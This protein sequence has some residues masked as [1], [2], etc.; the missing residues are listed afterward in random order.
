MNHVVVNKDNI[1]HHTHADSRVVPLQH[2]ELATV[3]EKR[4]LREPTRLEHPH[5][6]FDR[7]RT[8]PE[9]VREV[10]PVLEHDHVT[11]EVFQAAD[12]SEVAPLRVHLENAHTR[13]KLFRA[14][15][16]SEGA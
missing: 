14:D 12:H 9:T 16:G 2:R 7:P 5:K 3:L 11:R 4:K 15:E 1:S 10:Y 6:I 8:S 13:R